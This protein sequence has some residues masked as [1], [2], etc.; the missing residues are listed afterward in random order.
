LAGSVARALRPEHAAA[1]ALLLAEALVV[2][3]SCVLVHERVV[4]DNNRH[5]GNENNPKKIHSLPFNPFL[6][7]KT[8][9]GRWFFRFLDLGIAS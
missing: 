6:P 5:R 1:V 7:L 4:A 3:L 8:R 2:H 9:E